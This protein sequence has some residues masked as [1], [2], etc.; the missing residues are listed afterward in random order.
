VSI[1]RLGRL[2]VLGAAVA[3]LSGCGAARP[4]VAA[5]VGGNTI[6]VNEVDELTDNLCAVQEDVPDQPNVPQV[7]SGE[8]ARNSALQALILR[9]IADQMADDYGVE[10]G[11]DFQAQVHQVRL[12]FGTV[13][14]AKVEAALPAYTSIA[15]FIDIMRQ[16]G[17]TT[18]NGLSDDEALA[19]G[20][21]LAQ[22]WET[23]HGVETNPKFDSF[24]IGAQEIKS[25]RSDLAF[26]VSKA[27]KDAEEGA[28]SYGASLPESQRCG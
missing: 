4:G 15:Y 5:E 27:A 17:D 23:D 16:I 13:D 24:S 9:S 3:L 14:D 26:G 1:S 20:I 7:V 18:E 22:N 21:K 6:T 8:Q 28:D 11:P 2:A 25:E 12:Q 10:S 19:A